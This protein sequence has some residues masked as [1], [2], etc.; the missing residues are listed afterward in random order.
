MC[1]GNAPISTGGDIYS[2]GVCALE[3][4]IYM[5]IPTLYMTHVCV[6]IF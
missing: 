6:C 5:Y 2:F 1:S 3:V 4:Y